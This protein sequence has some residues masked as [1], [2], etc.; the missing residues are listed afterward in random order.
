[1]PCSCLFELICACRSFSSFRSFLIHFYAY[2]MHFSLFCLSFYLFYSSH[3]ISF[4]VDQSK[5]C[6][7]SHHLVLVLVKCDF[8]SHLLMFMCNRLFFF[9]CLF[10]SFSLLLIAWDSTYWFRCI[11]HFNRF[12][13][14]LTL[15]FSGASFCEHQKY[16]L[17]LFVEY[18]HFVLFVRDFFF[19]IVVVCFFFL[20]SILCIPY[21]FG[22]GIA[23]FVEFLF[24]SIRPI[25]LGG[26]DNM[27]RKKEYTQMRSRPQLSSIALKEKP[28]LE[29]FVWIFQTRIRAKTVELSSHFFFRCWINPQRCTRFLFLHFFFVVERFFIHIYYFDSI[30]SIWSQLL[31]W[32]NKCM[33]TLYI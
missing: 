1:M 15:N 19:I 10:N 5:L 13:M 7:F 16:C 31:L 6:S 30:I 4:I 18:L 17:L 3:C 21:S 29:S 26:I 23:M 25:R 14:M 20:D 22:R 2:E 27:I 12:G 9:S 24:C 33:Y 8:N 28:L 32:L 11:K